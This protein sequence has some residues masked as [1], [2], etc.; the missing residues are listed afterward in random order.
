MAVPVSP[1]V[2]SEI[3]AILPLPED[4]LCTAFIKTFIKFPIL[5]LRWYTWAYRANGTFTDEYKAWLCSSCQVVDD[6]DITTT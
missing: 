1:V 2:P 5:F 6:N 3:K 4:D